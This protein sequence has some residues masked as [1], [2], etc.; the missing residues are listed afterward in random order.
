[1]TVSS[2]AWGAL[3]SDT[4][5]AVATPPGRGGVGVLRVSG[6]LSRHIAETLTGKSPGE[7]RVACLRP[8]RD[9]RGELLDRGLLLYFAAPN[10]FTGEEVLEFHCHGSPVLLDLLL[11][12]CCQQGARL[13]QPGEFSRRAFL[14]DKLDLSQAEA[15]SDL[16]NSET[17]Q[18][19]RNAT[20]SLEGAFSQH[21]DALIKSVT[22][23]RVYVEAAI[24][25][26]DE[27][28][29]FIRDSD[30]DQRLQD[31][32]HQ[33]QAVL[34]SAQQGALIRDGI[35]LVLA[36]RP[37]AGKSSLLNAL[38]GTQRAIVTEIAGTTRDILR[39]QIQI[40]GLPLHI[41]D[42]AGLRQSED[43]VEQ[44]GVRRAR[45]EIQRADH[46]LLV[47]D[48]STT[49]PA[50]HPQRLLQEHR[51]EVPEE[52]PISFV[53]NKCDLSGQVARVERLQDKRHQL[54][55]SA[56]TGAGLDL[57]R[58]HL[59]QSIGMGSQIEGGFSARRRHLD[60][61]Q[62]ALASLESA[63]TQLCEAAAGELVAEDLR[64]CHDVLG[65][66]TGRMSS[67]ELLGEIF[68]S[69]CIGK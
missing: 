26:P 11:E 18:A 3:D 8:F 59:K 27:E 53:R 41:V 40:D 7:P 44:E 55:V 60:A 37:N 15:I 34:H 54:W 48:D 51:L 6:P 62:R 65:E 30:L 17:A 13:A 36:G 63:Q 25:F 12:A 33:L 22:E 50:L 42:T 49:E 61:L 39:E 38:S 21:I 24:D 47:I 10:S 45:A 57:L 43:K 31:L 64:A 46:I 66:I 69:F 52:I 4:I 16:I 68:S 32:Q 56:Q 9:A 19:V 20:R 2:H 23:L 28:I 14:N 35:T 58:Q 1:M 5:A 67:D 29:D